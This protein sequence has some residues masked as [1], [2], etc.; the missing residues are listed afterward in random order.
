ML[1][2]APRIYAI[3]GFNELRG[4]RLSVVECYNPERGSWAPAPRALPA[5]RDG[6][7]AVAVAGRV[8]AVGGSNS[9]YEAVDTVE[10]YDPRTGSWE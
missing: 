7:G 10:R 3:G 5:A 4:G 1:P 6:L 2:T 8:Y 9:H